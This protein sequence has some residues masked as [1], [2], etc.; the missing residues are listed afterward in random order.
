[1]V[2]SKPTCRFPCVL[3]EVVQANNTPAED[4]AVLLSLSRVIECRF[5]VWKSFWCAQAG[6]VGSHLAL[7]TSCFM[8]PMIDIGEVALATAFMT[9]G[10]RSYTH[11]L[12]LLAAR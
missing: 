3:N 7:R 5:H 11:H 1:M 12:I 9:H 6:T 10:T 8:Y 2:S 4:P